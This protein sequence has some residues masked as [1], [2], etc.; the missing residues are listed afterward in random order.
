MGKSHFK[1]F[2]IIVHLPVKMFFVSFIP[3]HSSGRVD[4]SSSCKLSKLPYHKMRSLDLGFINTTIF[5]SMI[6]I[7][8]YYRLQ[9]DN[10]PHTK[11]AKDSSHLPPTLLGSTSMDW[12]GTI[13]FSAS[14]NKDTLPS[15][16]HSRTERASTRAAMV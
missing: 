15:L 10:M 6:T 8:S 9:H 13:N 3:I 5:F 14:I 16:V 12:G 1:N 11:G 4:S 2:S 7:T